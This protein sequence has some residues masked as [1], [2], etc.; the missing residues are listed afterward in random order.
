MKKK[1]LICNGF[2]HSAFNSVCFA[3][4]GSGWSHQVI[5]C[6]YC[7]RVT[8]VKNMKTSTIFAGDRFPGQSFDLVMYKGE[9]ICGPCYSRREKNEN[10]HVEMS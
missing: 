10:E 3:C 2:G 6:P 7:L 9:P 4:G 5:T 1:C 8:W